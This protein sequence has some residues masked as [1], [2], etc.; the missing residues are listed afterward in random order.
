M[1][2]ML[3]QYTECLLFADNSLCKEAALCLLSCRNLSNMGKKCQKEGHSG[4]ISPV[5]K[6]VE[7][8]S[9]TQK[10]VRVSI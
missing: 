7:Q 6:Q 10:F 8:A 3:G 9:M 2:N 4:L 1:N 5:L